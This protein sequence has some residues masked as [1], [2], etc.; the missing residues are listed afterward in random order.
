MHVNACC[1]GDGGEMTPGVEHQGGV[2]KHQGAV[3]EAF[4]L[5]RG[6]VHRLDLQDDCCMMST[7]HDGWNNCQSRG[8]PTTVCRRAQMWMFTMWVWGHVVKPP[9]PLTECSTLTM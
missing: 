9:D 4:R 6:R 7:H 3:D 1:T 5:V 2:V 8:V